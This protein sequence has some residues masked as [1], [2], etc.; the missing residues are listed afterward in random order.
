V[1]LRDVA[2]NTAR[3]SKTFTLRVSRR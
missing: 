1:L 3:V 2:G